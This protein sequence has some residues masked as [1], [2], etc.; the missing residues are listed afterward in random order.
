MIGRVTGLRGLLWRL[1]AALAWLLLPVALASGWLAAVVTDTDSYVDT[2]GPLASDATV[3]EAVVDRLQG[4]IR[5]AVEAAPGPEFDDQLVTVSLDGFV[6]SEEFETLWRTVNRVTHGQAVRVL[7][8]DDDRLVESDGVVSI[9]LGPVYDSLIRQL[10]Q[11]GLVNP[12]TAPSVDAML[13]LVAADDLDRARALYEL[14]DA[15]GFWLPALWLVL[16]AA[17]LLVAPE[18]RRA[19]RWLAW[20]SIAGLMALS[21]VLLLAR[22][23]VVNQLGSSGDDELV[24]A[25][26]DVLVS[27]LYYAIG[28]MFLVAVAVLLLTAVLGRRRP[29]GS[30]VPEARSS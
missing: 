25:I 9:D 15:A 14:L 23:A 28:V 26:W 30:T 13:P 12:A 11:E 2:V 6:A 29:R 10:D 19:V 7:E 5:R 1:C 20:G 18:R 22:A 8:G 16:V 27:R 3:Q 24:R 4:P 17:A 21:V